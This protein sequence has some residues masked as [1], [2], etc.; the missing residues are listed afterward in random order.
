MKVAESIIDVKKE[1]EKAKSDCSSP[2]VETYEDTET[3][4]V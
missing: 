1:I 3:E 4:V 2:K